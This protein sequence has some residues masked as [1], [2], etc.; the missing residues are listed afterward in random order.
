LGA[1]ALNADALLARVRKNQRRLTAWLAAES[2]TSHR[3]YDADMP[4]WPATID[5]YVTD[6]DRSYLH[7]VLYAP[8]RG[9]TSQAQALRV[10]AL[11]HVA[12]RV[13]VPRTRVIIKMRDRQLG[14]QVDGARSPLWLGQDVPA[15]AWM[16]EGPARLQLNFV[17]HL[18]TGVFLDHR[19]ARKL[20]A[21]HARGAS[22]LNLFCYTGAFT[23]QAALAGASRTMSVD[24]ST[25]ATQ[26]AC[27]NLAHNS[28]DATRHEVVCAG[29]MESLAA[30]AS[31]GERFDII[32]CDPPSFS[33]SR[34]SS[35]FD[36]QADHVGLLR[37]CDRVLDSHG[38]VFF[39]T[40]LSRFVLDD[41]LIG[42]VEITAQTTSPD[43]RSSPPAH[44]SF[45][46]PRDPRARDRTDR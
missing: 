30:L 7:C 35:T 29:T 9:E 3:L 42:A 13:G 6:D 10:Q 16:R 40:N 21:G 43:F 12:E 32:V 2:I 5:L 23:V 39:S 33:K 14:G 46:W 24:L 8:L 37:A 26:V 1:S 19:R 44:R 45:W 17:G 38:A 11:L 36:V 15:C 22:V 18:D 28:L 20:V 27:E 41:K 25:R 31:R 4:E 34:S